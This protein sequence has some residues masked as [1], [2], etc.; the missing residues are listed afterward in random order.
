MAKGD[1]RK[2]SNIFRQLRLTAAQAILCYSSCR[3][4]L[5]ADIHC[6]DHVAEISEEYAMRALC[7][8]LVTAYGSSVYSNAI[9]EDLQDV[10]NLL[11]EVLSKSEAYPFSNNLALESFASYFAQAKTT[12]R[13][14]TPQVELIGAL[15]EHINKFPMHINAEGFVDL[16]IHIQEKDKRRMVGQFYTPA[17]IVDYCFERAIESEKEKFIINLKSMLH[18]NGEGCA[19]VTP[20][21]GAPQL[22]IL[23]PSCGTGNFLLGALRMMDKQC[24]DTD[25]AQMLR[26]VASTVF[27]FELD[28]RAAALAR[29]SVLIALVRKW[30]LLAEPERHTQ[31][32]HLWSHLRRN[33]VNVD[34]LYAAPDSFG[35]AVSLATQLDERINECIIDS[36]AIKVFQKRF[37]LI[38]TNPPYVSYG[39]RNQ[40]KLNDGA[41]TYLRQKYPGSSEYKI[42]IHSIFQDIALRFAKAEGFACLLVPDHFLTGAYYRKLRSL[43]LEK[44]RLIS[45]AE[46]PASTISG[47]VVGRWCV[48]TYRRTVENS[49]GADYSVKLFTMAELEPLSYK[50][51]KS[52]LVTRDLSRYR[53]V[54]NKIDEK[55]CQVIDSLD[56]LS[57]QFQGRTGIRA[58]SGQRSIVSREAQG[59]RFRPG[60]ISG[61]SVQ[62]HLVTWAGD[63]L[64]VDPALLFKGGFDESVIESP[65]ILIRQTGDRLVAGFD[66]QKLYHLNNIHSLSG[67]K[68]AAL[69]L[70]VV[71]ALLNSTLWLYLYRLKTREQGRALA[72]IDIETLETMP[73]PASDFQLEKEIAAL[74]RLYRRL[75]LS[76]RPALLPSIERALDRMI[77][78]LYDLDEDIVRQ[79]E[80]CCGKLSDSTVVLPTESQLLDLQKLAGAEGVASP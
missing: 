4:A 9:E 35:T 33:I 51:T 1:E 65:K 15:Y 53:L 57:T 77:Y 52:R 76:E 64:N 73:L 30:C 72:Q 42:R 70:F 14:L 18:V 31:M 11:T 59:E 46:L 58:L 34:T 66:D 60:L 48:A 41:T 56:P 20:S 5:Q 23:D 55:L 80:R 40:P 29:V 50:L 7:L 75:K 22:S 36:T 47:A 28:G 17:H 24:H 27:G 37:D 78:E 26:V 10:A 38:I 69:S 25:P 49:A 13:D 8:W 32:S 62:P 44:S 54:F 45:L 67:K 12:L 39:A 16:P 68:S 43:I 71:D 3:T 21:T 6:S 79:I 63:Y 61:A 2:L 74:T 19:G